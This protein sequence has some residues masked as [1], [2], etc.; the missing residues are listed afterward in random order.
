LPWWTPTDL[1]LTRFGELLVGEPQH[2]AVG[3]VK[4]DD[5]LG[6]EML[7]GDA[8]RALRCKSC[9]IAFINPSHSLLRRR[10]TPA[11]I[12]YHSEASRLTFP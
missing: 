2:P 7:L 5:L 9:V 4:Q 6:P 3:A 11:T 8:K 10:P 12:A 1:A